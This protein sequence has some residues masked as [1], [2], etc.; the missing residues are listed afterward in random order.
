MNRLNQLRQD[1]AHGTIKDSEME[2]LITLM[3]KD[4]NDM[5]AQV[6]FYGEQL[7]FLMNN[8]IKSNKEKRVN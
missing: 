7:E 8:T 6:T 2:E 3:I 5:K 4:S 1:H